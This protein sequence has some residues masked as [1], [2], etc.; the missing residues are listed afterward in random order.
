MDPLPAWGL[1]TLNFTSFTPACSVYIL[2]QSPK[3]QATE[4]GERGEKAVLWLS[5]A[6]GRAPMNTRPS[7]ALQ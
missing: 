7:K 6:A 4:E 1:E 2:H 5:R 3:G